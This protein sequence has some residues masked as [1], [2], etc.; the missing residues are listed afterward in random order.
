MTRTVPL[1]FVARAADAPYRATPYR[2]TLYRT[3]R[4]QAAGVRERR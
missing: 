1:P 2:A 4:W 3:T